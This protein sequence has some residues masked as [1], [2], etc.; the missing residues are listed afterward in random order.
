MTGGEVK[1]ITMTITL[2]IPKDLEGPLRDCLVRGDAAAA[3]R[4]LAEAFAPTVAAMLNAAAPPLSDAEFE[5]LVNELDAL[6]EADGSKD[7]VLSDEAISR[8]GIYGDHP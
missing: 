4:M 5:R 8:E 7:I 2:H 1:G 6:C 3:Q